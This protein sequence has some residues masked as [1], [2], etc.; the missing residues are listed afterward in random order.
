MILLK[1][2]SAMAK[3]T[4]EKKDKNSG[5][6][7]QLAGRSSIENAHQTRSLEG[8]CSS[9]HA[10]RSPFPRCGT[11]GAGF[12][13]GW[14]HANPDKRFRNI[15]RVDARRR[16]RSKKIAADESIWGFSPRSRGRRELYSVTALAPDIIGW[17]VAT[18]YPA[19]RN[20]FGD[21]MPNART[22]NMQRVAFSAP[23]G[24][25]PPVR[26]RSFRGAADT[27]VP[28][29]RMARR[30]DAGA[31]IFRRRTQIPRRMA[32]VLVEA[33]Y[34]A[35]GIPLRREN[36]K[37]PA[38]IPAVSASGPVDGPLGRYVTADRRRQPRQNE[39]P[40]GQLQVVVH[41]TCGASSKT[42][43]SSRAQGHDQPGAG[44]V[45]T[46]RAQ[47]ANGWLP[48]PKGLCC[49]RS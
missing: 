40:K 37:E 25:G 14:R 35:N 28:I 44:Y 33:F 7:G 5:L 22:I 20:R 31:S 13:G 29:M 32:P 19:D 41:P 11:I 43:R 9:V 46:A 27:G 30:L 10:G 47:I 1:R 49:E 17:S 36:C 8:A 21:D 45:G 24:R 34:K 42:A 48:F 16:R 3:L 23:S 38:S 2:R 26:R 15:A 12:E 6:S 39:G 18:A 4:R